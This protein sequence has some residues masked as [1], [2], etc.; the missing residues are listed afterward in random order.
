MIIHHKED[1]SEYDICIL[2]SLKY[3][4]TF[5]FIP[6]QLNKKETNKF[7][8]CIF[9]TPLLFSPFGIQTTKNNKRIIDV[10]F[11]NKGNDNSLKQFGKTLSFIYKL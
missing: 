5:T 8:K 4:D 2:K 11:Q 7:Q 10:S 1:F 6:I 3:S 9:Q